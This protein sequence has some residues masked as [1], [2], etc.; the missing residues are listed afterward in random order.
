MHAQK[1]QVQ[2]IICKLAKKKKI[3]KITTLKKSK[4]L[5]SPLGKKEMQRREQEKAGGGLGVRGKVESMRRR[6][7][8]F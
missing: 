3:V 4:K 2:P 1:H 7:R 8:C 6:L 5:K